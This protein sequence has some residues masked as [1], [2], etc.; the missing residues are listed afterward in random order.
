MS[1]HS[2]TFF[3]EPNCTLNDG[4]NKCT[5]AIDITWEK[6]YVYVSGG[7]KDKKEV[8]TCYDVTKPIEQ[9]V[10][11]N[12]CGNKT[13]TKTCGGTGA[14]DHLHSFGLGVTFITILIAIIV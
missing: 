1:I 13:M 9:R 6:I 12:E 2:N 7:C 11:V 3:I 8:M 4:Y 5:P 14:A 10:A